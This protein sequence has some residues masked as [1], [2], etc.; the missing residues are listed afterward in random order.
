MSTPL[1]PP[2]ILSHAKP[3]DWSARPTCPRRKPYFHRCGLPYLIMFK[4]CCRHHPPLYDVT[5][6]PIA[7]RGL[8]VR[9]ESYLRRLSSLPHVAL[10]KVPPPLHFIACKTSRLVRAA[11]L[12]AARTIFNAFPAYSISPY[13]KLPP[14]LF[15]LPHTL[16]CETSGLFRGAHLLV[17]GALLDIFPAYSILSHGS[18]P[19]LPV[20]HLVA[21]KTRRLVRA[22]HLSAAR[23]IFDAF[24]AYFVLLHAKSA[25]PLPLPPPPPPLSSY[26]MQNQPI[27]PRGSPLR[28]SGYLRRLP[29]REPPRRFCR[30][31]FLR[32]EGC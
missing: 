6:Q 7:S 11:C 29:G 25:P 17:T 2:L 23:A 32:N 1:P 13:A 18:P 3:A 5:K 8:P 20:T 15:P 14:V 24:P 16:A 10:G 4:F 12:S 31:R 28:R 30:V 22:A 21:C 19:P 27:G 26:R 9:D